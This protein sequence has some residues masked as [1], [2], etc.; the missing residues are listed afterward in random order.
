MAQLKLLYIRT[1]ERTCLAYQPPSFPPVPTYL[2]TYLPTWPERSNGKPK[3]TGLKDGLFLSF[4][5]ID[6]GDSDLDKTLF[7]I[8]IQLFQK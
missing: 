5:R 8:D 3:L 2:H 1:Y 6:D 7:L 4:V